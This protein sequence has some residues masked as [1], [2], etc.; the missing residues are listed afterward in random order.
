MAT[1]SE[2]VFDALASHTSKKKKELTETSSTQLT[3]PI[4]ESTLSGPIDASVSD[5]AAWTSVQSST[6]RRLVPQH[7]LSKSDLGV[8]S[9]KNKVVH[10]MKKKGIP[11]N[12][13]SYYI[14][15]SF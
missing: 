11:R 15:I 6:K 14:Y 8:D 5:D 10:D 2:N 4:I 3:P 1:M 13:F 9:P 7:T 12:R